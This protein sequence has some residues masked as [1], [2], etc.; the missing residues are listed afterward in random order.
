MI[1][2]DKDTKMMF[3]IANNL[4]IALIYFLFLRL[5]VVWKMKQVTFDV[6]ILHSKV[7]VKSNQSTN[8]LSPSAID[9]YQAKNYI[10][11]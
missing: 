9:P 11:T 1:D 5:S 3:L 10:F 4:K 6:S 2:L 8:A 7:C